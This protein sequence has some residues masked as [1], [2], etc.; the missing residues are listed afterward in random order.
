[1]ISGCATDLSF[2]QRPLPS[3]LVNLYKLEGHT[4]P[5]ISMAF[6]PDRNILASGDAGT[7]VRLWQVDSGK[8]LYVIDQEATPFSMA[9]SPDGAT[10]A[11]GLYSGE[12]KLW[13]TEDGTLLHLLEGPFSRV[14]GVAFS[15][16][17]KLLAGARQDGDIYLWQVSDGTLW[18]IL[19]KQEKV[20]LRDVTFAPNGETLASVSVVGSIQF[21]RVADGVPLQNVSAGGLEPKL[22]FSPD[23]TLLAIAHSAPGQI[24]LWDVNEYKLLHTL[25]PTPFVNKI[26]FSPDGEVLTSI[27]SDFKVRFWK[28]SDATLLQSL[29]GRQEIP[30]VGC[31]TA[32]SADGSF[33]AIGKLDGIV[34]I[35]Q[36]Q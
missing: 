22:F 23:E 36:M 9:V 6:I 18:R 3:K 17:G 10:L 27:G 30:C 7:T 24:T 33:V 5:V 21:W 8:E 19:E 15:P 32:I 2:S 4:E 34:E 26:V 20:Q 28:V 14:Y 25:K 29:E 16:D 12:V 13:R 11:V 35:W 31:A 1:M